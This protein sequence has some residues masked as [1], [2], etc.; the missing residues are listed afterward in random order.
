MQ[1]D[2][3]NPEGYVT[4]T[5]LTQRFQDK[6]PEMKLRLR[7]RWKCPFCGAEIKDEYLSTNITATFEFNGQFTCAKCEQ[8]VI[9][10]VFGSKEEALQN[11]RLAVRL[12]D[13]GQAG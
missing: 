2:P 6:K 13:K 1:R 11:I 12:F 9:V 4:Q 7:K 3:N 8:F 5:E 10:G